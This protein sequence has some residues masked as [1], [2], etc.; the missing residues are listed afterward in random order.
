MPRPAC[1]P[2]P[3]KSSAAPNEKWQADDHIILLVVPPIVWSPPVTDPPE[4]ICCWTA[5]VSCGVVVVAVQLAWPLATAAARASTETPQTLA[6]TL[7]GTCAF[8]GM[9]LRF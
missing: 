3:H 5:W 7:I 2:R 1:R 6:A 9:L 8:T 4:A